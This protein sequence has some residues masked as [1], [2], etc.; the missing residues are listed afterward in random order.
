M[1]E[2]TRQN[3][4][5]TLRGHRCV[6]EVKKQIFHPTLF[7]RPFNSYPRTYRCY[8][9]IVK[10][11][12][13]IHWGRELPSP[14]YIFSLKLKRRE[15]S[16]KRVRRSHDHC[17]NRVNFLPREISFVYNRRANPFTTK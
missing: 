17:N 2:I 11:S 6:L 9:R 15:N 5:S 16:P 1:Y 7:F 14:L 4:E 12:K 8:L 3:H 10:F 13:A